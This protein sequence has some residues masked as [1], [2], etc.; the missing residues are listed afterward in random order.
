M[1]ELG[2]SKG[3]L[4]I[5]IYQMFALCLGGWLVWWDPPGVRP[6]G[7]WKGEHQAGAVLQWELGGLRA[8]LPVLT[9][10]WICTAVQDY[11]YES[12]K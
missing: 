9:L 5:F 11:I 8:S 1:E 10:A 6:G 3:K 12:S 2:E 7:C 4:A